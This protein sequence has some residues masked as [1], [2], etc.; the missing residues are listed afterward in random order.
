[1]ITNFKPLNDQVLIKPID[2]GEQRRGS[3]MIANIDQ[4]NVTKI[5]AVIAVGPGRTS[6]FGAFIP[7]TVKVGDTVVL[8][9]IGAQRVVVDDQELWI[10]PSREIIA[11]ATYIKD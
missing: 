9:K 8:P 10:L 5:G 3:I 7:V 2:Q 4:D 6:E 11:I 1:M